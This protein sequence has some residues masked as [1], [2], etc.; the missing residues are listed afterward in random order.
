MFAEES[1]LVM[2]RLLCLLSF[3]QASAAGTC[4][5]NRGVSRSAWRAYHLPIHF[6]QTIC[7]SVVISRSLIAILMYA[8]MA[9]N[10]ECPI[11][12]HNFAE[13]HIYHC[14]DA[15]CL[16]VHHLTAGIM[17]RVVCQ[18]SILTACAERCSILTAMST[19]SH[20]PCCNPQVSAMLYWTQILR[21][22]IGST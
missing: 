13:Q 16:H 19:C 10:A 14:C 11:C 3:T 18:R 12:Y 4:I 22:V 7:Y 6:Q 1:L 17:C 9:K 2:L 8:A 21:Y 15:L 20:C 5:C